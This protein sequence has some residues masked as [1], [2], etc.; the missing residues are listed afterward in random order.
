MTGMTRKYK[1]RRIAK[2]G[3]GVFGFSCPKELKP[4]LYVL[5]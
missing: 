5:E 3:V 2:G 1:V 4:S